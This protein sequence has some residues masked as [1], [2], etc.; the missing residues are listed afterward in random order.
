MAFPEEVMRGSNWRR[1]RPNVR[2][3]MGRMRI[4]GKALSARVNFDSG[5]VEG[6]DGGAGGMV[7]GGLGC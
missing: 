3:A 2:S 6:L 4:K 5:G 1:E 7:A